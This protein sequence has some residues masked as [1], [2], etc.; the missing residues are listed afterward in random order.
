MIRRAIDN[1]GALPAPSARTPPVA[2][3]G[4]EPTSPVTTAS[5]T[6]EEL[7]LKVRI[8]TRWNDLQ[9]APELFTILGL[10]RSSGRE[11]VR[12]SFLTLVRVFHPDLLPASLSALAPKMRVIF[13][14][15]RGAHDTLYDDDRPAAY[16]ATL[17]PAPVTGER[18]A[19]PPPS[20][21]LELLRAGA[22]SLKKRSYRLAEEQFARAHALDQ[23]GDSLA[24]QA[25]AIYSDPERKTEKEKAK[26]MLFRALQL[27]EGCDR[28]HCQLGVIARVEG[29]MNRAERHFRE[30]VR[31]NPRHLEAQH[32]LRLLEMRKTRPPGGR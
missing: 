23:K 8:E 7:L 28:A 11:Q 27:D 25:W 5:P 6:G 16:C 14:S 22:A 30:A 24:A 3:A 9:K 12:S 31:A 15:L 17:L 13:E 32:E 1:I 21:V 26:A 20:E 19:A 29:D 10:P 18:S 2:A 4:D